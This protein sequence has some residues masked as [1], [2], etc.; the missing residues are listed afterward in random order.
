MVNVCYTHS[1]Q[2][3]NV[4][5]C[6]L[7]GLLKLFFS[8]HTNNDYLLQKLHYFLPCHNRACTHEQLGLLFLHERVAHVLLHIHSL[9]C[10]MMSGWMEEFSGLSSSSDEKTTDVN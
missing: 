6:S 5:N 3:T 4:N 8:L 7:V 2:A 1:S 9:P 10:M